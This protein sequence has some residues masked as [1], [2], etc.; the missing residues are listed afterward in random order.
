MKKSLLLLCVSYFILHP[1]S[2]SQSPV[3]SLKI[4][5]NTG[6]VV[7]QDNFWSANQPGIISA[8]SGGNGTLDLSGYTVSGVTASASWDSM[9]GTQSNVNLSG[10]NN[11]LGA[12]GAGNPSSLAE[13]LVAHWKLDEESGRRLDSTANGYTLA[14]SGN[15]TFTTGKRGNAALFDGSNY[16]ES[17]EL[18]LG[19]NVSFSV[20]AKVTSFETLVQP[21]L[22][23][24]MN[25]GVSEGFGIIFNNNGTV[26]FCPNGPGGPTHA[27]PSGIGVGDWVH[28]V[29]VAKGTERTLW[30]NG[31][32]PYTDTG[33]SVV[34]TSNLKIGSVGFESGNNLEG[35]VDSVSVWN[36]ALSA[37]EVAQLYNSGDGLSEE[38]PGFTVPGLL[39]LPDSGT[40]GGTCLKLNSSDDGNVMYLHVTSAGTVTATNAP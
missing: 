17:G 38:T 40:N 30:L 33:P 16:L 25:P 26:C 24:F 6:A 7:G 5:P 34:L 2:F 14:E 36:R 20:W 15:V 29:A 37:D 35:A 8:I 18:T 31:T 11:D 12:G 10:F 3:A 39:L 19:P 22:V 1:S 13:G 28:V 32:G 21:A 27:L 23:D 4:N 9:G